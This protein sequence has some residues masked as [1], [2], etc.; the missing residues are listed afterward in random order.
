MNKIDFRAIDSLKF[1]LALLVILIHSS[2]ER[3]TDADIYDIAIF[4]SFVEW[5]N[6]VALSLAVPTF[7]VLS[8][9]LFF[10]NGVRLSAKEYKNKFNNRLHSLVIPYFIW[11]TIGLIL[12]LLKKSEPLSSYFPDYDQFDLTISNIL[13]GYFSFNQSLP[14]V[15]SLWFI[16]NLI[17]ITLLTPLIA[18]AIRRFRQYLILIAIML[19]PLCDLLPDTVN[20]FALENSL[21]FFTLGGV[22]A[23]YSPQLLTPEKIKWW[24]LL[25]I[26]LCIFQKYHTFE[27]STGDHIFY[28]IKTFVGAI[29]LIKSFVWMSERNFTIPRWLTQTSFFL[30]AFHALY[31]TFIGNIICKYIEPTTNL[32]C[33]LVYGVKYAFLLTTSTASYFILRNISPRFTS[34]VCGGRSCADVYAKDSELIVNPAAEDSGDQVAEDS[35]DPVVELLADTAGTAS[36]AAEN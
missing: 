15:F 1:V 8:G 32:S 11:N 9:V 13:G 6:I 4:N 10:R 18:W 20:L 12:A 29:V 7:F 3:H 34:I 16:R 36:S 17:I 27:T 23:T 28:L 19:Y 26:P 30:F 14:Y 33:F 24:V 31:A 5:I 2:I 25:F 22:I 21:L 35:G